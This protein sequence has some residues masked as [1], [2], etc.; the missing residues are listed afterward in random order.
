MTYKRGKLFSS[1]FLFFPQKSFHFFGLTF[2]SYFSG[3]DRRIPGLDRY[4]VQPVN[5]ADTNGVFNLVIENV[6]YEDNAEYECQ[7]GPAQYNQPIRAKANLTVLREYFF[8]LMLFRSF[9]PLFF[10]SL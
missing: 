3:Y 10:F 4:S 1:S 8:G 6:T 5:G 9:A 7:V 2:N